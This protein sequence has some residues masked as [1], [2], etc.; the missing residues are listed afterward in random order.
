MKARVNTFSYTQRVS[1]PC[2]HKLAVRLFMSYL[3]VKTISKNTSPAISRH[4][5]DTRVH[6]NLRV[7]A[8]VYDVKGGAIFSKNNFFGTT[9]GDA[10]TPRL[11]SP[12]LIMAPGVTKWALKEIYNTTK[13]QISHTQTSKLFHVL[14]VD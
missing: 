8:Q 12:S 5:V 1:K 4:Q 2:L 7:S 11:R 10:W 14:L 6:V 9:H 3:I 13:M